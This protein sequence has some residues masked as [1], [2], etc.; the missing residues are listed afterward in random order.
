MA[1]NTIKQTINKQTNF[2]DG[3]CN[4]QKERERWWILSKNS[5]HYNRLPATNCNKLLLSK[6]CCMLF[7]TYVQGYSSKNL[8]SI[9]VASFVFDSCFINKE[10]SL[11]RWCTNRKGKNEIYVLLKYPTFSVDNLWI[12]SQCLSTVQSV[13]SIAFR[14]T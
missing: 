8:R 6:S 13:C 1:L 11:R 7:A 12:Y 4:N 10:Y 5:L 9:I 2:I 3:W 14:I